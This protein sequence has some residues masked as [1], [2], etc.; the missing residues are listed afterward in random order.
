M[1]S[2]LSTQ[3]LLK[4]IR[5]RDFGAS[6]R[7][8]DVRDIDNSVFRSD[9][10]PP[11]ANLRSLTL[12]ARLS[13]AI[14]FLSNR[15]DLSALVRLSIDAISLVSNKAL[16]G[17][18]DLVALNYP[19]MKQLDLFRMEDFE[20][21]EFQ[22][23]PITSEALSSLK[24]MSSLE[25]FTLS[26]TRRYGMSDIELARII[27]SCRK[28]KC[29]RLHRDPLTV[30]NDPS[31]LTLN[32]LSILADSGEGLDLDEL[33]VDVDARTPPIPRPIDSRTLHVGK[34]L[35]GYSALRR[36]DMF[37]VASYLGSVLHRKAN[38][39]FLA[40]LCIISE[41]R[42]SRITLES[43]LDDA[44]KEMLSE[45]KETWKMV[46]GAVDLTSE[47][48]TRSEEEA[49]HLRRSNEILQRELNDAE[50]RCALSMSFNSLGI[51]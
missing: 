26:S 40:N 35:F 36:L 6:H 20:D 7:L 17:F 2:A 39:A 13:S 49:L 43:I 28:I 23:D 25:T 30:A 21:L 33:C 22:G 11:F 32:L 15:L 1:L 12:Q 42:W 44:T 31:T 9:L 51:R 41:C 5:F 8:D 47:T 45:R 3:L 48:R 38:R 27:L 37:K 50:R 18:L 34:L 14:K 16:S 10:E 4:D 29:F 19:G 24:H 46:F